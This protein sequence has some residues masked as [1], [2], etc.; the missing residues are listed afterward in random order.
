VAEKEKKSGLSLDWKRIAPFVVIFLASAVGLYLLNQVSLEVLRI[1]VALTVLFAFIMVG[2]EQK[3]PSYI[4]VTGVAIM[5]LLIFFIISPTVATGVELFQKVFGL[6]LLVSMFMW[7]VKKEYIPQKFIFPVFIIVSA[8][9][10]VGSGIIPIPQQTSGTV[11]QVL[12]QTP[13]FQDLI[14]LTFL[15]VMVGAVAWAYMEG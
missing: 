14:K 2:I 5:S 13:E 11:G 8:L 6:S 12:M 9:I 10:I 1:F 3:F 4:F 7:A 15:A